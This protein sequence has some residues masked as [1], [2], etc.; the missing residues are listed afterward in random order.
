MTHQMLK[1]LYCKHLGFAFFIQLLLV[2]AA[3]I[4]TWMLLTA[5]LNGIAV[6]IKNWEDSSFHLNS[7][8]FLYYL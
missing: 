1:P 4:V 6:S 2:N 3:Y 5:L 8:I 7:C